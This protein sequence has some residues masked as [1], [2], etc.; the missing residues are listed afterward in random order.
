[1]AKPNIRKL[2]SSGSGSDSPPDDGFLPFD[3]APMPRTR[4]ALGAAAMLVAFLAGFF[5]A[6]FMWSQQRSMDVVTLLDSARRKSGEVKLPVLWDAYREV[7]WVLSTDPQNQEAKDLSERIREKIASAALNKTKAEIRDDVD[8]EK[9]DHYADFRRKG[10]ASWRRGQL[11]DAAGY[12]EIALDTYSTGA[13]K[14]D[15]FYIYKA[16][17]EQMANR[18][19]PEAADR[20]AEKA[21]RLGVFVAGKL[22]APRILPENLLNEIDGA[23]MLLVPDGW[24]RMGNPLG[25]SEEKPV[26]NVFIEAF[27]MD[28]TEI[29]NAQYQRF[30][31]ATNRKE[32]RYWR[33]PR[34]DR[35]EQPVVGVTWTDAMAYARWAGK[36]L[37][38]E[39]EWERASRGD[40]KAS[41]PWGGELPNDAGVVRACFAMGPAGTPHATM[42]PVVAGSYPNA[43]SPFGFLDMVGNAAEWVSDRYADNYYAGSPER[44]PKGP[45][46][47]AER[48]VRGGS[49]ADPAEKITVTIRGH[50]H[51]ES[52]ESTV[53]FRCAMDAKA[54]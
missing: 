29:T 8:R 42:G 9:R 30:L 24:V 31:A 15:L 18:K 4:F 14:R 36:R 49:W 53:G 41:Y 5:A 21:R 2:P 16:L 26:H 38:T 13:L 33:D 32:P 19:E 54:R 37:P 12:F 6:N 39:A 23:E 27:F 1:M 45:A 25:A 44:N 10:L 43:A 34:F 7:S 47:G 20:Y 11:E 52:E 17:G 22:Q 3:P 28:R 46:T 51:A 40:Q 50:L 35:P 48:V